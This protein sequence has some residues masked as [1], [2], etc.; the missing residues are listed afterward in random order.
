LLLV[1]SAGAAL[2]QTGSIQGFLVDAQSGGIAGSK[3]AAFDEAKQLV[4]RESVSASDGSFQLLP[5]PRG[6]YTLKAETAGFKTLERKGLVLDPYQVLNLGQLRLELGEVTQSIS[7]EAQVPL[8]ETA[9]G[10]KS[11]TVSSQQVRE[12]S[13]N[14]RDFQSLMRTLPGVVSNNPSD[15]RLA[16]NNTNQFNVNGLRGSM[17]NVY[18]DGSINTETGANDGQYTQISLDA[19]GEFKVQTSAFAAEYGRNPGVLISIS[20]RSGG[21]EFHGTAYDFLRNNA[22]DARQPFD[23]TGTTPKL[24][25][26]QFGANLGGPILKRG[27]FFFFKYEGTRA[28]RP[29]GNNFRDLPHPDLLNGDFRRL[30]RGTPIATAPQFDIGTVF[31]PGTITRNAAGQITGGVAYPNNMISPSEWSRNAPAFLK[32]LSGFDRTSGTAIP[33]SPQLVRVAYQDTYKFDKDGKVLRLD[34]QPSSK[35]NLF[36]RWADDSQREDQTQGVFAATPYPILPMYR[37]KPGAS[38][39]WNLVNVISPKT[40]NEFIFTY[41]HF[42]QAVEP[43]E[44]ADPNLYDRD[45]L[46]FTFKE[47]YPK[48][49][50]GNKFPRFN[51]GV[52]D[53]NFGGFPTGFGQN[54]SGGRTFAW[55][56]NFTRVHGSHI[57]KIGVLFNLNTITVFSRPTDAISM[58]FSPSR[59]NPNDSNNALANILLGNYTSITQTNGF[60]TSNTR[61]YGLEFYGQDSWKVNRKLTLEFG[62]RYVFMGPNYSVGDYRA[63]YFDPARYD[64]SKAVRIETG[65]VLNGSII[66][67]SGDPFNGIVLEGD[68]IPKGFSKHRKNQVSPRFGFA[69]DPFG[70]G[71][72]SVRGGF[73]TFFERI[74]Q[75][76]SFSVFGNPPNVY[77]PRVFGGNVD[78]ISPDLVAGGARFPVALVALDSEGKIPTIYSWSFG[79]QRELPG[80]ASIDVG[81]VGNTVRHLTYSRDINQL[82]LGTTTNTPLLQQANNT[83]NAIRTFKGY[84]NITFWDFGSNSNYHALQARLSRRFARNLTANVSYTWSKAI[85]ELDDTGAIGYYLDRARERGPAGFD[86]THAFTLDYVYELPNIGS[87]WMNNPFGRKVLDGWQISGITRFWS[88]PPLTITSNGDAGTL[89]GG[90]RANYLGGDLYPAAKSRQEYFNPLVFARPLNGSL[91]DT[92]R[93]ILRGPGINNWDIS[94]FKNT[95]IGERITVQFRFETFNTFNH[96]Q[97][98]GVNASVAGANPGAPVTA[99]TRGTAGQVTSTRDPRNIQFGL[100]LYF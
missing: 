35:A 32:I 90:I 66:P 86:R 81:Y 70:D 57:F 34:W 100:K 39:S 38:W 49:N 48:S 83:V 42:T 21:R 3:V 61:F 2:A 60:F 7:V 14:G 5:L 15:F 50:P 96:T 97:W 36:F 11:F 91:G 6:T 12:L 89:G 18:L 46:G 76:P 4:V 71:K 33:G 13:L 67:N 28:T 58:D 94:L 55:T 20:T 84:T 65:P 1:V 43:T 99:A 72:T 22:L 23:T 17:N 40:T 53:C 52:G 59:D 77:N 30:L 37:K 64:P 27:L 44:N 73:G 29:L 62:A 63:P 69:Y 8:V 87:K 51:C 47:L 56:D 26:N 31:R 82:P 24:R 98:A 95:K 54:D 68:G 16:F 85:N 19:V 74:Q 80:Q 41:N 10:M 78:N 79:I 88:G 92:G 93:G 45:K 9:S 25:F 75:S